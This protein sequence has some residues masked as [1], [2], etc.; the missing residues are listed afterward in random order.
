MVLRDVECMWTVRKL[1]ARAVVGEAVRPGTGIDCVV[2]TIETVPLALPPSADP[3]KFSNFG[4]Q[5]IGID[6]GNLK[7]L[8]FDEIQQLL[9]KVPQKHVFM[10]LNA[11]AEYSLILSP[12][13]TAPSSSEMQIFLQSSNMI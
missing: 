2:M 1:G 8:E 7:P 9:Y 3:S 10:P 4:R 13:S 11:T 5:V 6:P 12:S